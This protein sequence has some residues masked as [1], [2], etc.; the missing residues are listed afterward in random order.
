MD[1]NSTTSRTCPSCGSGDYLFRA[2]KTIPPEQGQGEAV[3]T[4]YRCKSCG[5]E[6]R[7]RAPAKGEG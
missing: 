3:E 5:H 6:W 4:K 2:R 1:Q 7:V